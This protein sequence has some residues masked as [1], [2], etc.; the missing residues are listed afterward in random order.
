M[1]LRPKVLLVDDEPF[2]L[3]AVGGG[4]KAKNPKHTGQ[5]PYNFFLNVLFADRELA[6]AIYTALLKT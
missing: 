6:Y 4:M 2:I 1:G 3:T 5:E